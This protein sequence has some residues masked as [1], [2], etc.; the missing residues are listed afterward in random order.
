MTTRPTLLALLSC[1]SLG[2]A[3]TRQD[4]APRQESQVSATAEAAATPDKPSLVSAAHASQRATS[5]DA[6]RS[7]ER[8]CAASAKL[9]CG[10]AQGCQT[11][12]VQMASTGGCRSELRAFYRC[13]E[14]E[15]SE[16]W[17]C[18]E[19]GTAAIREGYC[20]NEQA[21]FARCLE[22]N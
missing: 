7:C 21:Q 2:L 20:E 4:S 11:A 8:I 14:T 17:E 1:L 6:A 15:P 9:G 12:C 3:C 5:D 18:L 13:L 22:R 10:Q 16:H 19:D